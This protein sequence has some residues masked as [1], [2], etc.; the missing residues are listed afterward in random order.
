MDPLSTLAPKEFLD[1]WGRVWAHI[2]RKLKAMLSLDAED[3]GVLKKGGPVKLAAAMPFWA[4]CPNPLRRAYYIA[5]TLTADAMGHDILDPV[6]GDYGEQPQRRLAEIRMLCADG[7][8]ERVDQGMNRLASCM[9]F[10]ISADM[11]VDEVIGKRSPGLEYVRP[12]IEGLRAAR[13]PDPVYDAIMPN[14]EMGWWGT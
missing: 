9:Y 11:Q 6:E 7:N 8:A 4:G 3:S 2:A 5:L 1:T 13:K 10:D 14:P 12:V